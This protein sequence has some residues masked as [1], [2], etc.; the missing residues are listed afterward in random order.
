[1]LGLYIH[2]PFCAA[3]CNYCNFNRGLFDASLKTRY[4]DALIAEIGRAGSRAVAA[5]PVSNTQRGADTVYFGSLR[6]PASRL[7]GGNMALGEEPHMDVAFRG[8]PIVFGRDPNCE[9]PL[10][11][12]M[13]SFSF[14]VT[15]LGLPTTML[16]TCRS[17]S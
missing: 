14:L 15:V 12:S 11:A 8:Q 9:Q 13:I 10:N 16:F 6:M 5:H 1:M 3:I 2:I 4:V 7:L 17:C